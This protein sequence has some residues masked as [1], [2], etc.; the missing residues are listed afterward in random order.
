MKKYLLQAALLLTSI[1]AFG[2]DQEEHSS[3]YNFGEKN[4]VP[5]LVGVILVIVLIVV[6]VVRKKRKTPPT[7][8]TTPTNP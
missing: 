8:P 4:A 3:A 6:L 1:V 5:I 2:Q 7:P